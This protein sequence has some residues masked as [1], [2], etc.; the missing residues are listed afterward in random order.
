MS[1]EFIKGELSAVGGDSAGDTTLPPPLQPP[2][3]VDRTNPFEPTGGTSTP[4]PPPDDG[5]EDIELSNMNL[6]EIEFDPDDIPLLTDFMNA[7]DKATGLDTTLRFIEDKFPK[8]DF[9][10][11]GPI[12]WGNKEENIGEIVQFGPKLGETRVLK[13]DGSGLL[14]SFTDRFKKALCPTAEEILG[15]E[16]QEVREE[17]LKD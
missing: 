14:K 3:D 9:K 12:G 10:K 6:D 15:E 5:G 13:K 7:E 11:L 16:N 1:C 4:Y 8:V 2:Q 17:R